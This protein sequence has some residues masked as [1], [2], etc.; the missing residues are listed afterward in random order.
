MLGRLTTRLEEGILSLLLVSM[1]LIVFLEVVLR[2]AFNTG[3]LWIQEL[4]LHISAWFVLFGASYGVKVGAHIGVD[5]VVR[6]L[7]PPIRR[8]VS[9]FAVGL[10]LIYCSLFLYGSW[11]Y[12]AKMKMVGIEL[13]DMAVERWVAHSILLIGFGLL[14]VRFIQVAVALVRNQVTGFNL[15]DEAADALKEFERAK[16]RK[17][18]TDP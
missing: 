4:T 9:L 14:A 2:F 5:A 12:L 17:K 3:F 8:Y 6:T 15:P 10:C 13:E 18:E 1:T 11:V 7:P 16:S